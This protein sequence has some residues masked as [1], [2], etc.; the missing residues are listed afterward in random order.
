MRHVELQVI[1]P[2]DADEAYRRLA[3]FE[4]Y[5]ELAE[6]V[7][8]VTV[9]SVRAGVTI[10]RWEVTFRS[11]IL[12]WTEEDRYDDAARRI[13]FHQIEGDV[14]EFSGDWA[15]DP[16]PGGCRV[17]F[18]ARIDLGIPMLA[19]ALEP[20]AARAL[21]ENTIS[22]LRGLYGDVRVDVKRSAAGEP[23]PAGR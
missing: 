14:A 13:A 15:C 23:A 2:V 10:S 4:R 7:R 18:T 3:D 22:I 1:V 11:G 16:D 21:F 8:E 17:T 20:I 19:G 9:T 12:R 6:A 5:P